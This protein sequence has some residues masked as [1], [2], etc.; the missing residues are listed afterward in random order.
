MKLTL[1]LK[2]EETEI[3]HQSSHKHIRIL[4]LEKNDQQE[5]IQLN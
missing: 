3:G 1:M 2:C 4:N 5:V